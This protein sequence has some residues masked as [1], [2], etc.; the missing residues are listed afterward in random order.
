MADSGL[1][2][3]LLN[4]RGNKYSRDHK[5]LNPNISPGPFWN[6]SWYEMAI[7]DL[8]ASIDFILAKTGRAKLAYTGHSQG[9]TIMLV[10]L[11]LLPE[12]NDKI[13]V[14][15]LMAPLGYMCSLGIPLRQIF[16]TL[17]LF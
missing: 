7:Y 11:A 12:Y 9:G 6:F 13:S 10:L 8:P 14:A 1:D 16:Q 17:A 15:C 4:S 2:V 5:T 3:W